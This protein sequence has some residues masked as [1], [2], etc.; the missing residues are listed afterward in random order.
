[1]AKKFIYPRGL[2]SIPLSIVSGGLRKADFNIKKTNLYIK[3][4][5]TAQY[6]FYD[7]SLNP[8]YAL[9]LP[10]LLRLSNRK[11]LSTNLLPT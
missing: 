1:M 3:N 5:K 7:S 4:Y 9:L 6:I 8:G 11:G 2:T 10:G